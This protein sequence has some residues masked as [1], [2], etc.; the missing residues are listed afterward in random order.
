MALGFATSTTFNNV[1]SFLMTSDPTIRVNP[2]SELTY[3]MLGISIV[4]AIVLTI[5]GF[6]QDEKVLKLALYF[7]T[8]ALFS[9]GLI[10]GGM[11][12]RSKVVSFLNVLDWDSQLI[13]VMGGAVL[14]T[15]P[16]FQWAKSRQSTLLSCPYEKDPPTH[17]DLKLIV[18]A[19][20]F[21]IGWGLSGFCPGPAL[22]QTGAGIPLTAF[23]F[24]PALVV[25]M[26]TFKYG[27]LIFEKKS[28]VA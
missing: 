21:G 13:F 15:L 12:K 25:G 28:H 16:A 4:G 7:L 17:I 23:V 8:G 24:F 26:L 22:A 3:T 20:L 18:G 10:Y 2:L 19:C 6:K 9:I 14:V 1:S 11:T 5:I 27:A